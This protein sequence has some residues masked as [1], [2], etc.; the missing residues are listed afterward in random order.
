MHSL[1]A[2]LRLHVDIATRKLNF[3]YRPYLNMVA[4]ENFNAFV[5]KALLMVHYSIKIYQENCSHKRSKFDS[6]HILGDHMPLKCPL[7]MTLP[8]PL[9]A[10][11]SLLVKISSKKFLIV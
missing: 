6:F 3:A 10:V 5:A 9:R 4:A 11:P 7:A 2:P 1:Q 8:G